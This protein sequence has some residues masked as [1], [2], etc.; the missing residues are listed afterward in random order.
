MTPEQAAAFVQTRRDAN[1]SAS[2]YN[3]NSTAANQVGNGVDVVYNQ[4]K[5]CMTYVTTGVC[6]PITTGQGVVNSGYSNPNSQVVI[7][8]NNGNKYV[9]N[10]NSGVTPQNVINAEKAG[11]CTLVVTAGTSGATTGVGG[12]SSGVG[13]AGSGQSGLIEVKSTTGGATSQTQTTQSQSTS[14]TQT[15]SQTLGD[16]DPNGTS[17]S[18]VE[19]TSTTLRYRAKDAD[20][21]NEVTTLQEFLNENNYLTTA[22]TG[23][24][25]S[26]TLKAVKAFQKAN[27]LNPTGYVG[28]NTRTAIKT[29][30][31]A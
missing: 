28:P 20:T 22:P 30:S 7:Q 19:L 23:F 11:V 9:C 15:T 5:G 12:S 14:Q 3:P 29:I 10:A 4:S 8:E 26:G 31:C 6:V 25:G 17:S 2:T 13:S 24:F 1:I 27:N 16:V 21:N 18:C